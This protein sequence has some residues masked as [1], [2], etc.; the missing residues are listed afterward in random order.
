MSLYGYDKYKITVARCFQAFVYIR[1]ECP[2]SHPS[3]LVDV[4]LIIHVLV[5]GEVIE[6]QIGIDRLA[7][8]ECRV[9]IVNGVSRETQIAQNI[10]DRFTCIFLKHTLER[11][12]AC[13]EVAK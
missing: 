11:V 12:L 2:V 6:A 13:S 3:D 5:G 1:N 8:V 10:A 9:V 7:A 4:I